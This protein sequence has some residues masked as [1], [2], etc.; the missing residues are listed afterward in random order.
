M[1][2]RVFVD[3]L[4]LYCV[5]GLQPWERQVKQKVRVDLVMETDCRPAARGD[6]PAAALDYKAVSKR[7]QQVVEGSEFLLVETLAET[8]AAAVLADFPRAESVSVRLAKP[9]AVRFADAVG[10]EI[11]RR[12][13]GEDR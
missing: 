1:S 6:D 11:Q 4:E 3:G 2:D 13:E 8:I 9:G 5:I 7:V 10:V 12:R